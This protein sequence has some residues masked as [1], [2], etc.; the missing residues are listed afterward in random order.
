[1]PAT[2]LPPE[3]I[4]R[5]AAGDP[6]AR[7]ELYDLLYPQLHALARGLMTSE[8]ANVHEGCMR[9]IDGQL[10]PESLGHFKQV[11]ARTIRRVLIDLT[12]AK[13]SSRRGA[14]SERSI[15]IPAL[16]EKPRQ[17]AVEDLNLALVQLE[18]EHPELVKLVELCCFYGLTEIDAGAALGMSERTAGTG[19]EQARA[20][21]SEHLFSE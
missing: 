21:L 2:P 11:A 14:G 12:R 18:E 3:L 15:L 1:M 7:C 4:D 19:W 10:A 16:A 17:V 20:L 8:P 13:R 9:L 5:S 6:L